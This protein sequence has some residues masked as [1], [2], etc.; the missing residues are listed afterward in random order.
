MSSNLPFNQQDMLSNM[1]LL[2]LILACL[3]LT[4]TWL[5]AQT[6]LRNHANALPSGYLRQTVAPKTF[7]H[8]LTVGQTEYRVFEA[9]GQLILLD[10]LAKE[11]SVSG[12]EHG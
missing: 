5:W 11:A 9:S 2:L 10:T 3:V 6:K 12:A 8:S 1:Q 7:V 4:A